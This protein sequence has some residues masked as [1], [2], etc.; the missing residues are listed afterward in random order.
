MEISSYDLE[1]D[2][3]YAKMTYRGKEKITVALDGSPFVINALDLHISQVKVQGQ[4][5]GFSHDNAKEELRIDGTSKGKNEIDIDFTGTV[6]DALVGLY[7]ARSKSGIM[8]TTQFES[9]G[10]RP[11][12]YPTRAPA[13]LPARVV[14]RLP[15]R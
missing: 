12:R 11:N 1:L 7:K 5:A 10:S 13:S 3:D 8:L 2:I 6:N 14:V 15:T 4:K 9:T